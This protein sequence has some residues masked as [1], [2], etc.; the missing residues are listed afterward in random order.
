MREQYDLLDDDDGPFHVE[1]FPWHHA[2]PEREL[3]MPDSRPEFRV[4]ASVDAEIE[5]L[6]VDLCAGQWA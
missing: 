5:N 2:A 1:V 4:A 3:L 6:I